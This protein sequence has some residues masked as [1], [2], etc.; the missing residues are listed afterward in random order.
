VRPDITGASE[1]VIIGSQAV[2]VLPY[3]TVK[4][5]SAPSDYPVKMTLA[6]NWQGV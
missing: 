6:V 5:K 2:E 1:F 4:I 3:N